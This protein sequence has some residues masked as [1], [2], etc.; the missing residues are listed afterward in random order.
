MAIG[1]YSELSTAV[2][3]F[4]TRP[5][6][7]ASVDNY[8][9]LTE[10][11]IYN[12]YGP[13]HPLRVLAMQETIATGLPALPSDFLE[14]IRLQIDWDGTPSSLEYLSPI[15]FGHV[16]DTGGRPRYFTILDN[17]IQTVPTAV[18]GTYQIDYYKRF[19]ALSSGAPT[20]WIL[21]NAPSIYLYGCLIFLYNHVR[22][23]EGEANALSRFG[24]AMQALRKRDMTAQT[25]G[26]SL[27]MRVV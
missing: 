4:A 26:G 24:S 27:V 9:A 20:N 3:D 13:V 12:G 21:S 6:L 7:S 10:E 1:T 18:G 22:D 23:A 17:S 16:D 2:L 8:I 15:R 25:T 14:M 11:A 19:S 5:D